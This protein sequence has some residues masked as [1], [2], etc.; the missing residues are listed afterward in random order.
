LTDMDEIKAQQHHKNQKIHSPEYAEKIRQSE[1]EALD[2]CLNNRGRI[3]AG[4]KTFIATCGFSHSGKS[5]L[6]EQLK[7]KLS[8]LVGI[9]SKQLH[10]IVN[11]KFPEI[12]DDNGSFSEGY[13]LKQELVREIRNYLIEELCQQG[14]WI[15]NDSTNLTI[16]DREDNFRPARKYGYRTVLLWLNPPEDVL[17]ERLKDADRR[18]VELG[19]KPYWVDLYEKV[20]KSKLEEPG[21]GEAEIYVNLFEESVSPD[22]ILR[23]IGAST[24]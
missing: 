1:E 3:L 19:Y 17:M 9:D 22:V 23:E 8:Y 11:F 7:R 24:M 6:S 5:F 10:N 4:A 13:F 12:Q 14:W 20:Q 21:Q 18:E 2:M 15:I 16:E